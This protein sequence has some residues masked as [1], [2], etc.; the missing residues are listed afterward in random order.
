MLIEWVRWVSNSFDFNENL[1]VLEG[2][3]STGK[4]TTLSLIKDAYKGKT[5]IKDWYMKISDSNN[6]EISIVEWKVKNSPKLDKDIDILIPWVFMNDTRYIGINKTK[7]D[8]RKFLSDILWIDREWFFKEVWINYDIKWLISE[9]RDEKVRQIE[10]AN[11]LSNIKKQ[12]EELEEVKE[13]TKVQLVTSNE[14]E[15]QLLKDRLNEYKSSYI[16]IK[17][18]KELLPEIKLVIDKKIEGNEKE[19]QAMKEELEKIVV[20]WKEIRNKLSNLKIKEVKDKCEYC[21]QSLNNELAI[22]QSEKDYNNKKL[23]LETNLEEI[24][25]SY[26]KLSKEINDF[27]LIETKLIKWNQEDYEQRLK[28]NNEIIK[29]NND[30]D[31]DIKFNKELDI[32]IKDIEDKIKSF[33]LTKWNQKEYEEYQSLLSDYNSYKSNKELLEKQLLVIT[34]KIKSSKVVEIEDKISSY[35]ETE[36]S[37]IKFIENKI[38]IWDLKFIFFRESK[39]KNAD[40]QFISDF[41][42]EYKGKLYS[43]L[44]GWEQAMVNIILSSILIKAYNKKSG[45]DIDFILIDNAEIS[46]ENLKLVIKEYLQWFQVIT[47]R[48]GK[49]DL[50]LSNKL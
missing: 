33:K 27:V 22:K 35:K 7:E 47:T 34:D 15:L 44:S 20:K 40:S 6:I 9:L 32:K 29:Y 39:D 48:I 4:S 25:K 8:K 11:E 14:S 50:T 24:T 31:K 19:L 21:W 16:D 37:F 49:W 2:E 3:N 41:D 46:T 5:T 13:P 12:L 17:E 23:E 38:T 1:N 28:D 10:W 30:I 43:N 45:G 26:K 18:K 42:I 36:L